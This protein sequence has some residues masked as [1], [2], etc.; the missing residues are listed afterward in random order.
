MIYGQNL[1]STSGLP[2]FVAQEF[3]AIQVSGEGKGPN[4]DDSKEN[5]GPLLM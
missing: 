4:Y 2:E 3:F 1:S 5:S